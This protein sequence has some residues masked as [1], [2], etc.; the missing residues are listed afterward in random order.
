MNIQLM[1]EPVFGE[2]NGENH[3]NGRGFT[4]GLSVS[5]QSTLVI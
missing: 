3:V 1:N 2:S 5:S 4:M